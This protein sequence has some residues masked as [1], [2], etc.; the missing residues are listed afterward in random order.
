ML[1]HL[2]RFFVKSFHKMVTPPVPLLWSPYLF[3]FPSIFRAKKEMILKVFWWMLM[4]VLR[5][6]GGCCSPTSFAGKHA[7]SLSLITSPRSHMLLSKSVITPGQSLFCRNDYIWRKK[8]AFYSVYANALKVSFFQVL[9]RGRPQVPEEQ[10]RFSR[11]SGGP[12]Y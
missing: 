9:P 11:D 5:V 2:K 1:A 12:W 4:G 8:E 6:F 7:R 3:F 10:Q